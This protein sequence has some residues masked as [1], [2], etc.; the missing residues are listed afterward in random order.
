MNPVSKIIQHLNFRAEQARKRRFNMRSRQYWSQ[1]EKKIGA[2][3]RIKNEEDFLAASILSIADFTDEIVII[4]NM[5]TDG[6]P[7]VI[8]DLKGRLGPKLAVYSYPHAVTRVG[9]EYHATYRA[10][11]ESPALLHNF[12]NWCLSKC[13]MPFVMS[14]DGDM[15]ALDNL[16]PR[17][18]S[19]KQSG[20]LQFNFGGHNLSSDRRHILSWPAG[21]EPRIYPRESTRSVYGEYG[22]EVAQSWVM[23]ENILVWKEPVY[24]HM[25][26][27][28][29]DPGSNQ[30][31]EFRKALEAGIQIAG[32]IPE[33][34]KVALEEYL[35]QVK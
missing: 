5:S 22:G 13:T 30:S 3:V 26:Y 15:I 2:V 6:T 29:K 12:C 18:A 32:E 19:F 17:V 7:A 28:K 35:P 4:D 20:D 1:H 31:P 24:A 34:V 21:I 11:P 27:C 10:N 16:A 33:N 9:E 8:E 25:K 23:P 14:W